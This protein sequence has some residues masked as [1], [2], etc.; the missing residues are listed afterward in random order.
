MG[1][2]PMR[3]CWKYGQDATL[4]RKVNGTGLSGITYF[5]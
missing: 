3:V 5:K 2:L 1:L 4:I